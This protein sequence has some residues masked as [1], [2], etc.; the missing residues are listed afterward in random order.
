MRP[1]DIFAYTLLIKCGRMRPRPPPNVVWAIGSAPVL[2]LELTYY[3]SRLPL[4]RCYK[5]ARNRRLALALALAGDEEEN[6][7]PAR[8]WVQISPGEGSS[9]V[10]T[11]I[12]QELRFHDARFAAYCDWSEKK[13][14]KSSTAPDV[15]FLTVERFS[16][17]FLRSVREKKAQREAFKKT[18]GAFS[19]SALLHRNTNV[20]RALAEKKKKARCEHALMPDE[21]S[22]TCL[23]D[24]CQYAGGGGG[25]AEKKT[26]WLVTLRLGCLR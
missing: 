21:S 23:R 14:E 19:K 4:H 9:K 13:V 18:P 16:T 26:L 17:F 3:V 1:Q 22:S 7:V 25:G 15:V 2:E 24:L 6:H 20:E 11:I 8:L 12:V 10:P 5:M